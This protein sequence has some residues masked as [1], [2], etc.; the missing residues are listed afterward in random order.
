MKTIQ[1]AIRFTARDHEL[2]KRAAEYLGV[3]KSD[4]I[5]MALKEKLRKLHDEEKRRGER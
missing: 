1:V 5:R 4:V 3:S 2:L